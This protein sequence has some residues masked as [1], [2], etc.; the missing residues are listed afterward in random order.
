MAVCRISEQ[1][2][3]RLLDEAGIRYTRVDAG[4]AG[5]FAVNEM[6]VLAP[7]EALPAEIASGLIRWIQARSSRKIVLSL[8]GNRV[9]QVNGRSISQVQDLL[10]KARS[11]MAIDTQ[12]DEAG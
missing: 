1:S 7:C 2:F 6:T 4:S 9:A 10:P 8:E 3:T 11:L 12:G 5:V